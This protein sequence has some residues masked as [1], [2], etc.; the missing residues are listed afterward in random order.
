MPL[1]LS[2]SSADLSLESFDW[3]SWYHDL[4]DLSINML[5]IPARMTTKKRKRGS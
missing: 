3:V 1:G 4:T 5:I 2:N